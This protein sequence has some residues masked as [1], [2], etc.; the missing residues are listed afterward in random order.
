MRRGQESDDGSTARTAAQ[1]STRSISSLDRLTAV[2]RETFFRLGRR[3]WA[4]G[5]VSRGLQ[6]VFFA[7]I[8]GLSVSTP[9]SRR[10]SDRS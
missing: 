5:W 9:R 7:Q 6:V 3:P 4:R 2:V 10:A 1:A 8:V